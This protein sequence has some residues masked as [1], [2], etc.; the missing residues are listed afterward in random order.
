MYDRSEVREVLFYRHL[1]I[2]FTKVKL[3]YIPIISVIV[4]WNKECITILEEYTHYLCL[5]SLNNKY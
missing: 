2:I 4:L 5:A 3:H 1:V